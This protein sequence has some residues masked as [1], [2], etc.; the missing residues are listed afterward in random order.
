MLASRVCLGKSA[1]R[2]S[3]M[4]A[5]SSSAA[6]SL[7]SYDNIL[8]EKRGRVAL[9]TLN[10]PKALNALC[11]AL[12]ADLND[13][14]SILDQDPDTGAIVITGSE[15]AFAAGAD[16]KE[17]APRGYVD[18]YMQNKFSEW[19]DLMK[20]QTPVI[21]AVNG[22]ALGGGCEMAMQCDIILAGEKAKFGQPEI[23][24]GTIPGCGGTQRLIRAVGKSKAMQL[25]L[26]GD[27]IDAQEA[28]RCG[29]VSSVHPV[30]ELVDHAVK[31]GEKIAAHSK[32][33]VQMCKETVNAA[34]ELS[35]SQGLRFERRV[36]HATFSTEDRR[37]G[38]A[39]FVD[40]RDA[41]FVHN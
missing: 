15:K 8:V 11:D 23:K 7:P 22:F 1:V 19:A 33:I 14:T 25:C 29:L 12:I 9:I 35:L 18:S 16:I 6:A 2:A 5:L 30:D 4:R 24:L 27:M 32:P 20:V 34:E 17:M 40:K 36:F 28:H 26:T 39:A 37:E 10:R 21:A 3:M 13:A 41:D 31:V 38:M